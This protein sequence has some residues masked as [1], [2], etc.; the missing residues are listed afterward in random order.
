MILPTFNRLGF[1]R[2]AVES[3]FAQTWTDWELLIADDGSEADT[4]A[5][6]RGLEELPRVKVLYLPHTGRPAAVR[7]AAL[8]MARGA[9]IAF[10]DSDDVWLPMK[11][12]TQI[13][14]LRG[15]P[16]CRWSYTR[17]VLVD[18]ACNPTS[19]ARRTGGW[20][21][22]GGRIL[23]KLVKAETA[24][25]LPSVVVCRALLEEVGSFD[26]GQLGSEDYELYLRLAARS[27]VDAVDTPMTL[28]R[29]HGQHFSGQGVIPY[30]S[31]L[32]VIDKLLSS[33]TVNHLSA[34]LHEQRAEL[35]AG[36]ARRQAA[37]GNRVAALRTLWASAPCSWCYWKW[38]TG[39]LRAT[40][41]ALTPE[42]VGKFARRCRNG[43]SARA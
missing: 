14:S 5:F 18:E 2:P 22:P 31:N 32:R 43:W 26:E 11:L 24:I 29:R 8:R 37:S 4:R 35:V 15:H 17:F 25:A 38:W 27:D 13:A 3:V 28:V 30:E 6:L 40:A 33:G 34:L 36:L 41:R 12:A 16:S 9:Y 7:N 10:L 39:A 42:P 1:L 21:A 19:W 23:D 20:P